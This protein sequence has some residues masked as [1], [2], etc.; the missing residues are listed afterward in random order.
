VIF[1]LLFVF[2]RPNL[3]LLQAECSRL[4]IENGRMEKHLQLRE[5]NLLKERATNKA[6][7]AD[8]AKKTQVINQFSL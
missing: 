7:S 2:D 3:H 5:Q 6:L 4:R 1:Q 8:L